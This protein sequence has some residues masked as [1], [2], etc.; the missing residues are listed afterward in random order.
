MAFSQMPNH[1]LTN[2]NRFQ[3]KK[4]SYINAKRIRNWLY[5]QEYRP[6]KFLQTMMKSVFHVFLVFSWLY[7]INSVLL[8][9]QYVNK[10]CNLLNPYL[11][12]VLLSLPFN[13]LHWLLLLVLLALSHIRSFVEICKLLAKLSTPTPQI[14]NKK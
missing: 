1:D 10:E 6:I 4:P 9:R 12:T 7:L 13:K 8:R 14:S 2:S 11:L 5:I 3:I